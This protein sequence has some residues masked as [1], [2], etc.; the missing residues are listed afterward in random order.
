MS[1]ASLISYISTRPSQKVPKDGLKKLMIQMEKQ[2][3]VYEE[4]AIATLQ[5]AMQDKA[6][7]DSRAATLEVV[8]RISQKYV[9]F[10]CAGPLLIN[11]YVCVRQEILTGTAAEAER[12]RSLYEE[13]E[14]KS[15][16]LRKNQNLKVDQLQQLQSQV[17]VPH[18]PSCASG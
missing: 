1:F 17:E 3:L 4:A 10:L 8:A 5:R 6:E 7:A 11:V 14:Q 13:L 12:W 15:G 9:F 18:S 2:K 16:Q